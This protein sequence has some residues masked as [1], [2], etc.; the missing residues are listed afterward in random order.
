MQIEW[1]SSTNKGTAL[2]RLSH[3]FQPEIL[4]KDEYVQWFFSDSLV[5]SLQQAHL[6]S[7]FSP[8]DDDERHTQ[9]S[10]WF[11]ILRERYIDNIIEQ[12]IAEG[13]RQLVLLGAGF[14]TRFFRL[15]EIAGESVR[16]FEIDLPSTINEKTAILNARL[17]RMPPGLILIPLDFNTQE[18][19]RI[20]D[21]GFNNRLQTAFVWQ[22]VCYYLPKDTV[23]SVLHFIKSNMA[24]GSM[25]VFDCCSPLMTYKNDQIPGIS[26]SIDKLSAI[27]EPYLFGMDAEEMDS[28]LFSI[29]FASIK[30]IQQDEL[31]NRM[32]GR[33]TLPG[34][35]W[36]IVTAN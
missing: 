8:K 21:Y 27:G 36:Y 28:W 11:T 26:R 7:N 1:P 32:L 22:G 16:T 31:E 25:L 15:P 14:D 23:G 4:V 35:M 12:S 19:K 2:I 24:P 6:S 18:L 3:Q 17:G 20:K 9:I 10:Y 34:N 30:I 33:R 13:C 5:L 29:G